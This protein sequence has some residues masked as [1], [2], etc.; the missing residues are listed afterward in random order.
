MIC[1]IKYYFIMGGL[2]LLESNL[3]IIASTLTIIGFFISIFIKQHSIN[4]SQKIN[5]NNSSI[6][7]HQSFIINENNTYNDVKNLINNQNTENEWL[8]T[9]LILGVFLV[10]ITLFI[11]FNHLII[12]ISCLF[13]LITSFIIWTKLV[14]Y[15]LSM[16]AFLFY[17]IKYILISSIL[18]T[19]LFFNPVLVSNLENNLPPLDKSNS[20]SFI[21]SIF[22]MSTS[23]YTY[24][25]NLGIP[26][27]E[28]FVIFFRFLSLIFIYLMLYDDIKKNSFL[29]KTAQFYKN[30]GRLFFSYFLLSLYLCSVLYLMHFYHFQGFTRTILNPVFDWLGIPHK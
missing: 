14:K 1:D 13:T 30:T 15:H 26:S 20:I 8:N 19:G 11:K 10:T 2:S 5:G 17:A 23:T 21:I 9:F 28:T 18:L 27:Y 16:R 4:N 24:L 29:K 22:T 6:N 12:T 3:S 25:K 7:N